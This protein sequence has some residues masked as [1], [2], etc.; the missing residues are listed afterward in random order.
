MANKIIF[1]IYERLHNSFLIYVYKI[2]SFEIN[3]CPYVGQINP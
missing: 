2:H 3:S 1:S